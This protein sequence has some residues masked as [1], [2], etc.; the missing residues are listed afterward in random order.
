MAP[1]AHRWIR[2]KL[3]ATDLVM[4]S[5]GY[6]RQGAKQSLLAACGSTVTGTSAKPVNDRKA[7]LRERRLVAYSV[8]KLGF[9]AVSQTIWA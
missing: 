7:A 3:G 2:L 1:C 8:E 5:S 6:A 4:P 9:G